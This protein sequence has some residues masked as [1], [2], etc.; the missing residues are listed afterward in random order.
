MEELLR[1][2]EWSSLTDRLLDY[3]DNFQHK[4]VEARSGFQM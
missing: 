2:P 4:I 1:T 3:V